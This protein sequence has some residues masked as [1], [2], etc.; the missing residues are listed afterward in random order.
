[1]ENIELLKMEHRN[2]EKALDVLV[3][4]ADRAEKQGTLPIPEAEFILDF[5]RSYADAFHHN[6]EESV[7]FE[8]AAEKGMSRFGGPL[9]VLEGEHEEGRAHIRAMA[10]HLG[11]NDAAGFAGEARHYAQLLRSHIHTEDQDVFPMIEEY[12]SGGDDVELLLLYQ[13]ADLEKRAYCRQLLKKLEALS[14][15]FK[16]RSGS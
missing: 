11:D 5:L 2:I 1:M 14:S 15:T 4:M 9:E 6:K 8:R 16:F 13:N 12:L 7:L 10:Q 3:R